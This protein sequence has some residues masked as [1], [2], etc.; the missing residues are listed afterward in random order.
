MSWL[1]AVPIALVAGAWLLLPGLPIAYA[2]GLRGIVA[3]GA[4][5]VLGVALI[6]TT[7]VLAGKLGIAW[8]PVLPIVVAVLVALGTAI[9]AFRLRHRIPI[10][11]P[12]DPIGVTVAAAGGL[13]V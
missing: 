13:L 1:A 6:G 5:P 7:G 9:A 12:A 4:S 8:S 2:L 3:W 10:A 11:R